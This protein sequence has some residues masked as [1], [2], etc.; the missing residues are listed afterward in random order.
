MNRR[1]VLCGI[2]L[3]PA[4]SSPLKAFELTALEKLD[5]AFRAA[6]AESR[7]LIG[8][9]IYSWVF[10]NGTRLTKGGKPLRIGCIVYCTPNVALNDEQIS[11][12][13]E[14]A[15]ASRG[16]LGSYAIERDSFKDTAYG[17][18]DMDWIAA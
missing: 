9:G 14:R 16:R 3:L 5:L 6:G 2:A 15:R 7:G 11:E 18:I 8:D 10:W 17:F 12:R 13:V 4:M 1:E